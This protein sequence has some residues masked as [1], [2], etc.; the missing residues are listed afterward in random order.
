[1]TDKGFRIRVPVC[2]STGTMG[3]AYGT[4]YQG[5][6]NQVATVS[7]ITTTVLFSMFF[8]LQARNEVLPTLVS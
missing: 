4:Q 2:T 8:I 1:M 3:K 7:E 5:T 6:V